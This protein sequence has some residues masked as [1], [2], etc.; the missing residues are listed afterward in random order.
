MAMNMN[1]NGVNHWVTN[2]CEL[3]QSKPFKLNEAEIE[4]CVRWTEVA[5]F[6]PMFHIS[7]E[8]LDAIEGTPHMAKVRVAAKE[9]DRRDHLVSGERD[10]ANLP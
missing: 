2:V 5:A 10:E 1:M 3:L 7:S 4:I 9:E 8:F 6:L